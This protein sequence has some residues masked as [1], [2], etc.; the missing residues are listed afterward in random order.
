MKIKN[1]HKLIYFAFIF[2]LG[3]SNENTQT[4]YVPPIDNNTSSTSTPNIVTGVTEKLLFSNANAVYLSDP[5]SEQIYKIKDLSKPMRSLTLSP[6]GNQLAYFDENTLLIQ[7]IQ[8]GEITQ[9]DTTLISKS[10][11]IL[12]W[13]YDGKELIFSCAVEGRL[14]YVSIC[15]FDI[16]Q[17]SLRVLVDARTLG[18]SDTNTWLLYKSHDEKN[19]KIVFVANTIPQF[20][21]PSMGVIYILD[22]QTNEITTVLDT[23]IQDN[24]YNINRVAISP[25]GQ[26]ILF[27]ARIEEKSKIFQIYVDGSGLR[28]ITSNEEDNM[29][30]FWSPE[31]DSFYT[32]LVKP[33]TLNR[34][35]ILYNLNGDVLNS[36]K[37]T[38][39]W[40]WG[41]FSY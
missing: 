11:F 19:N 5:F 18:I 29:F 13:S 34:D 31:G 36:I 6:D 8:T 39:A 30:P 3:C 38:D 21:S 35:F 12:D 2:I 41:W 7:N 17:E 10:D 23:R 9:P 40:L 27:D 32:M 20:G 33:N 15:A 25:N 1:I 28:Q 22:T 16:K 26:S 14:P 37:L 24:I 4:Q